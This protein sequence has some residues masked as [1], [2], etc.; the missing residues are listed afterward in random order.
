[1]EEKEEKTLW[2]LCSLWLNNHLQK[3]PSE[4]ISEGLLFSNH[5]TLRI[6]R[7]KSENSS[8]SING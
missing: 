8:C 4:S 1:M 7:F 5:Y 6:A 2:S 3:K